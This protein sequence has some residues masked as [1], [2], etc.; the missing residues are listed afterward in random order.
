MAESLVL[1]EAVVNSRWF[2]RTSIILFLNKIDVFKQ[3][4]GLVCSIHCMIS[5]TFSRCSALLP[6]ITTV[7][8]RSHSL[9]AGIERP[10]SI[11]P[12]ASPGPLRRGSMVFL[13]TLLCAST[14]LLI[15]LLM[16]TLLP[17]RSHWKGTSQTTRVAPMSI[18]RP[19]TSCGG[20]CRQIE[21]G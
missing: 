8:C 16:T 4:L 18:R 17:L 14:H 6:I 11:I 2:M 3:K 10:C 21:R 5:R 13:T 12:A 20:S 7:V 19:S 9:S 1:F 15:P